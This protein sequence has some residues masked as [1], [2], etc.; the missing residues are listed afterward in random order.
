MSGFRNK[1][2]VCIDT[3][4]HYRKILNL[5]GST[6]IFEN[7]FLGYLYQTR[8]DQIGFI[9]QL[10]IPKFKKENRFRFDKKYLINH[11]D[12]TRVLG[13]RI[14]VSSMLSISVVKSF[15]SSKK[16]L[17]QKLNILK[18]AFL[19]QPKKL[20]ILNSFISLNN[21]TL[22]Y[23]LKYYAYDNF[24]Q[25]SRVES[26]LT[27][28]ENSANFKIILDA[29][30]KHSI[31]TIGYQHGSI[32]RLHPAYMYTKA[33]IMQNPVPDI[34]ITWGEKWS[35][36]LIENGNYKRESVKL[37]GQIRTDVIS[38]IVSNNLINKEN[39]LPEVCQHKIILFATQPQRDQTLRYKAAEDVVRACKDVC[40][41][42]LI[43]KLHPREKDPD[44]YRGIAIKYGLKN[45]SVSMSKDLYVLLKISDLV[46][47]C[48]STVGTEALYFRKPLIILDHLKQDTLNYHKDCVA[49][50]ATNVEELIIL[51]QGVLSRKVSIDSDI[52]DEYILS[53]TYKIDG[54]VSERVWDIIHANS[55]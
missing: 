44:F 50:Q 8:G 11:N 23:L 38:G 14:M 45:Y 26:L 12:R 35:K 3:I 15:I 53:S 5:E 49:Y 27:I 16:L 30:K 37:A 32:H 1:R 20:S 6:M 52:L 33:D 19:L 39:V 40:S 55:D 36:L 48:F 9:D 17:R 22:F 41:A 51:I 2:I 7:A 25:N 46:I 10:L 47:T 34:T 42:H 21:T 54:C 24:F 29:A 4:D 18:K 13:E 31:F 28:D 43:F